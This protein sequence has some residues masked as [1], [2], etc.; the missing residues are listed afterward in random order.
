[1]KFDKVY[2]ML[3]EKSKKRKIT[4]E[5]FYFYFANLMDAQRSGDENTIDKIGELLLNENTQVSS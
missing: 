3:L 1:M 4:V 2:K 5:K